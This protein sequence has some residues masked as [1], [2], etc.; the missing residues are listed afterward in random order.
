MLKANF[1]KYSLQFKRPSGT[2]RGV[3]T[4]KDSW[5]IE[6]YDSEN[7]KKTGKGECGLLKGLSADDVPNYEEKLKEVCQSIEK[8]SLNYHQSL[9]SFPSIR[10]GIEMAL[11]D[12]KSKENLIYFNNDFTQGKKGIPINGLI[13]MGNPAFMK[14]QIEEKLKAG[15]NCIKMKIGAI[16]FD[17]EYEILK[18]FRNEYASN[19][20]EIRVDANGA[21]SP[22]EA[23]NKLE[24][25]SKLDIHSVE[26]P[27]KT[28]QWQEMAQL[29][30]TT[31][32]PIALDEELIGINELEQKQKLLKTINPHYIILKPS[33]VGGFK[34]C[35]EW[36][37][38]A[39]N[40][41]INWWA[42]S[43]LESN[44]G[45]DAIAQWTATKAS[46]M[47]QGLGTGQLY[48]NNIKSSLKIEKGMLWR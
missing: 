17:N 27:I 39:K 28:G 37:S 8:Y 34:A 2:S 29:C 15:F 42:T 33:L 40:M 1:E 20:I 12:L 48:S 4:S 18:N 23:M 11:L 6:I 38:I 41:K 35:D 25:L 31:P 5:F 44:I 3:M 24:K 19:I 13:W 26:Q 7:P 36:I 43:A 10:M 14:S 22:N 21:F 32:L 9:E 46:K 47:H 30:A 16:D 45:L